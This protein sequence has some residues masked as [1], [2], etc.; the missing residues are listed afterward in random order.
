[1]PGNPK[2]ARAHAANCRQLAE[3]ASSPTVQK[4]FADLAVQWDRLANEVDD[5]HALLNA[6][7]EIDLKGA[8][9][10][11]LLPAEAKRTPESVSP[12]S[13]P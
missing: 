4:T 2:E 9:E 13:S 5:A 11:S 10:T 8:S 3:T 6:L 7:N 12:I 1:M